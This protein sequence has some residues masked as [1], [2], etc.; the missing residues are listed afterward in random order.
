[1]DI[2][3]L[4]PPHVAS[5]NMISVNSDHWVIPSH[6]LVDRWGKV[7]PLSPAEINYM[8]IV[9]SSPSASFDYLISETS[10]DVYSQSLWL[11]SSPMV[12][13]M[14]LEKFSSLLPIYM[15]ISS[16]IVKIF[17]LRAPLSPH[18]FMIFLPPRVFTNFP[19]LQWGFHLTRN[20][21]S[22]KGHG[23][24][25]LYEFYSI[26]WSSRCLLIMSMVKH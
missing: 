9:S 4:P 24:K 20:P 7:M 3:P 15:S 6:D 17:Q 21:P 14:C 22:P 19:S 8:E 1:M 23:R 25:I 5:F 13:S 11:G 18:G 10:L 2:F 16:N 26:I 12:M